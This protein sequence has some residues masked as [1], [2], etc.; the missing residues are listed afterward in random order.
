MGTLDSPQTANPFSS[1]FTSLEWVIENVTTAD[2]LS[3]NIVGT[4]HF[5]LLALPY[6][7]N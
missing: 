7:C 5:N 2:I 3:D 1:C 4:F 6:L